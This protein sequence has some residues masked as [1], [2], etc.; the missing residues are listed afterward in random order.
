MLG[1]ALWLLGSAAVSGCMIVDEVKKLP[2]SGK[3]KKTGSKGTADGGADPGE[4]S[5]T[6]AEASETATEIADEAG[7]CSDAPDFA[8]ECASDVEVR[9]C[10]S[11]TL[12]A[13]DCDVF[14]DSLGYASGACFETEV[15]NDCFV[16]DSADPGARV[17]CAADLTVCCSDAGDCFSPDDA[18]L[19]AAGGG[20]ATDGADAADGAA[21]GFD[22]PTDAGADGGE[23]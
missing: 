17:C 1:L 14:A 2:K 10:D 13:D 15:A 4:S 20:D 11:G 7:V 18:E 6:K 5:G 19:D 12:F 16:C 3:N 22:Q 21:D 9:Y 8:A 23:G